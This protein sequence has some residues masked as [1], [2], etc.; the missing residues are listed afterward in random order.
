[1]QFISNLGFQYIGYNIILGSVFNQMSS[2]EYFI[3]INKLDNLS[4]P[5]L[6]PLSVLAKW[7][8]QRDV[9]VGVVK[10]NWSHSYYMIFNVCDYDCDC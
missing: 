7:I 5:T 9:V 6:L 4:K 1:M 10:D 8:K 3:N 2:S